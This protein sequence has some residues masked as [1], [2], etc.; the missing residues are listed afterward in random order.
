MP[1]GAVPAPAAAPSAIALVILQ[2]RTWCSRI[3]GLVALSSTISTPRPLRSVRA[4]RAGAGWACFT[5][6]TVNAKVLPR[7]N[8]LSTVISPPSSST[9][10]LQIASPSPLPPWVRVVDDW[11]R[12]EWA[13]RLRDAIPG[14]TLHMVADAGHFVLEEAPEAVTTELLRFL[15][16]QAG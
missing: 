1:P 5:V 2:V 8:S 10:R 11:Q 4:S 6:R 14:A 7:P 12:V 3:V 15:H 16:A 13:H 9:R